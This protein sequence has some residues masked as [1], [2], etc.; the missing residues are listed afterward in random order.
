MGS[1]QSLVERGVARS[2]YVFEAA[3]QVAQIS[4]FDAKYVEQGGAR[5]CELLEDLA[6]LGAFDELFIVGISASVA[7]DTAERAVVSRMRD[8]KTELVKLLGAELRIADVRVAV[9]A[10]DEQLPS[11]DFFAIDADLNAVVVPVDRKEDGGLAKPLRREDT[12]PSRHLLALHAAT[13]LASLLGLWKAMTFVPASAFRPLVAGSSVP[14]VRFTQSRV[15]ILIS[16]SLPISMVAPTD[17]DLPV[18]A[19]FLPVSNP[20]ISCE[21][22]AERIYPQSLVFSP[23]TPPNVFEVRRGGFE[24]L[25]GVAKEMFRTIPAIPRIVIRGIQ[26]EVDNA[27]SKVHQGLLGTESGIK[28]TG[29]EAG[30]EEAL[31]R[32]TVSLQDLMADIAV[33]TSPEALSPIGRD[34]WK[35]LVSDYLGV[36]DGSHDQ[37]DLRRGALSNENILLTKRQMVGLSTTDIPDAISA[38]EITKLAVQEEITGYLAAVE[39]ANDAAKDPSASSEAEGCTVEEP[40][41]AA[42]DLPTGRASADRSLPHRINERFNRERIKAF[43]SSIDAVQN[44]KRSLDRLDARTTTGLSSVVAIAA[45]VSVLLLVF[46]L[47]TCTPLRD[48]LDI[49]PNRDIRDALFIALTGVFLIGAVLLLGSENDAEWQKRAIMIGASIG[50]VVSLGIVFYGDIKEQLRLNTSFPWAGILIGLTSLWLMG[51]AVNRNLKSDSGPRREIARLYLVAVSIYVL[52]CLVFGGV[53]DRSPLGDSGN[54][55]RLL[56]VGL[57]ISLCVLVATTAVIATVQYR[58]KNR[59]TSAARLVNFYRQELEDSTNALFALTGAQSQWVGTAVALQRMVDY[60]FGRPGGLE[61]FE[62][63]SLVGD[64]SILKFDVASLALNDRGQEG[65]TAR[66]RR[67]LVEPGWIGRQYEKAVRAFQQHLA[68]RTGS[69]RSD[70]S[71]RRP[72]TDPTVQLLQNGLDDFNSDRWTFVRDLYLG[73]YDT[74]L[75]VMPAEMSLDGIFKAVLDDPDAYHLEGSQIGTV[76]VREFLGQILPSGVVELPAGLVDRTFTATDTA[77]RLSSTVWWPEDVLGEYSSST[78]EV[79]SS[80]RES[81][82]QDMEHLVLVGVR[83]DISE[84]FAYTECVAARTAVHGP[85][86]SN[87]TVDLSDF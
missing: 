40:I 48:V 53:R 57:V 2:V 4:T 13:E 41:L 59:L 64:E 81:A 26:T 76:S 50:V 62:F 30:S 16:P 85:A 3:S 84:P 25:V 5:S 69:E 55:T 6:A 27:A 15:R 68:F 82:N 60:P 49:I 31:S 61:T 83:I 54:R 37:R 67:H 36:L 17:Q 75:A 42:V 63:E 79:N 11:H 77:R 72:E 33:E 74:Q 47:A 1:L 24:S 22:L 58:E 51:T 66:L 38:F 44:L 10:F 7:S 28:V 46:V 14:K 23:G 32:S 65:L 19:E 12:T 73:S 43:N 52:L 20:D 71:E 18:P 34:E 21:A 86:E 9:R 70:L 39:Q 78:A 56:I 87:A 8:L 35:G 29:G 45:W 80:A